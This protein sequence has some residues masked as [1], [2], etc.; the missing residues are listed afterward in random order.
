MSG[1]K[2]ESL[3]PE[4]Y[5]EALAQETSK[6]FLHLLEV[7]ILEPDQNNNLVYNTYYYVDDYLP[8][9]TNFSGEPSAIYQP[10]SF[11][12]DLGS[13]TAENVPRVTLTFD[14]G[15]RNII[16]RLRAT[17]ERPRIRL[18]VI[19]AARD[20][21]AVVTHREIGPINLEVDGFNFRATAVTM[22]LVVEPIL[23]EPIPSTRYTP[24]VSP[25]LYSSTRL[26]A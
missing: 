6:V 22:S 14:S 15:D 10:A 1:V 5:Q 12:T 7:D 8:V 3:S 2:R 23:S 4:F 17:D 20:P 19:M 11:K 9:E 26:N 16:R 13:D 18:S 21:N 24:R 25:A